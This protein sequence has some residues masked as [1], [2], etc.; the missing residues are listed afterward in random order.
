M[1]KRGTLKGHS[2]LLGFFSNVV[3]GDY[4]TKLTK[5]NFV[6]KQARFEKERP[7]PKVGNL[8]SPQNAGPKPSQ[9]LQPKLRIIA[10]GFKE[11]IAI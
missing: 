9:N 10:G 3:L 7:T 1:R 11:D 6:R 4:R 8:T 5:P 2:L